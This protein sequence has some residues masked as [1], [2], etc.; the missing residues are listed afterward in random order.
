[1]QVQRTGVMDNLPNIKKTCQPKSLS[2][3]VKLN[4]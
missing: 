4:E 2:F 1:M 3:R